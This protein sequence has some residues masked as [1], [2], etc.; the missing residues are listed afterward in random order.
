VPFSPLGRYALTGAFK[1]CTFSSND[2]RATNPRFS[3]DNLA[4]NLAPVAAL[5]ELAAEKGCRPGQLGWP[6]SWPMSEAPSTR[7][8]SHRREMES[9][10]DEIEVKSLLQF[11][12]RGST[13]AQPLARARE[14]ASKRLLRSALEPVSPP[15]GAIRRFDFDGTTDEETGCQREFDCAEINF[16][17][18]PIRR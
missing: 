18:L 15:D 7:T 13:P 10:L 6:G 12:L 3:V 16:G 1:P 4:T 17:E 14:F 9:E 5:T 8:N 2:F 11:E